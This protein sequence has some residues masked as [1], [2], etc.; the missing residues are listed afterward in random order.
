MKIDMRQFQ[1]NDAWLVF[2]VDCYVQ[3]QPV[4]IYMLID[5]ASAYVFG[6]VVVLS[7]LPEDMEVTEMLRTAYETKQQWP[8]RLFFQSPDPAEALFR[9][10]ADALGI[11]FQPVAIS[12]FEAVVGP[13]KQSFSQ[14]TFSPL[15][16]AGG[17]DPEVDAMEEHRMTEAFMTD[18]YDLCPCGSGVK[19]KFCCKQIFKEIT[20]AMS[21]A[22]EG[23][24]KAAIEWMGKAREIAGETPEVLCRYSIIYSFFDK[25]KSDQYL[26]ECQR[27][28]PS[29]PRANYLRGIDLKEQGDVVGAIEFYKTAIENYPPTDRYHL[30]EAW[31]NL[32]TAYFDLD[33]F[34]KAKDA[35]EIA[36]AYIPEDPVPRKNLREFI[37][38]NP[39][40]PAAVKQTPTT[41]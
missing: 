28:T 22:Q 30:N 39:A 36:L 33:D 32:G 18:S 21:A 41:H 37:Y 29:H 2:R 31:N 12:D 17:V 4:D 15:G 13:L 16:I 1:P 10:H 38:E 9:A 26:E 34:A 40:V 35:W 11:P 24:F 27:K 25:G 8:K 5:V 19:Y 20:H 6:Q 7:E 23:R 3:N 14:F